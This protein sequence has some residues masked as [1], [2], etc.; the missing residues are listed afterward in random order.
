MNRRQFCLTLGAFTSTACHADAVI[1]ETNRTQ[2]YERTATA[3]GTTVRVMVRHQS[4]K[5]ARLATAA[6]LDQLELIESVMSVYRPESQLS[7]LNRHRELLS[8]HPYLLRILRQAV[9]TG[10]FGYDPLFEIIEYHRTFAQLGSA[11]KAVLSHRSR[12]MRALI[13]RLVKLLS[14]T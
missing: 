9:G 8:P 11:V 5:A 3:L 2:I 10:G 13:P 7:K 4:K 1:A 6:G 14:R 12:A